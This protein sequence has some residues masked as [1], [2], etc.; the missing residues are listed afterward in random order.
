MNR[1]HSLAVII[2]ILVTTVAAFV[3]V[4]REKLGNVARNLSP[5][6]QNESAK[7]AEEF[8]AK[9]PKAECNFPDDGVAYQSAM[10]Q[11]NPTLCSCVKN[12]QQRSSCEK[13]AVELVKYQAIV[14]QLDAER[15]KELGSEQYLKM[16]QQAIA[17]RLEFMA[18]D[19]LLL[20]EG[21]MQSGNYA[22]A[23]DVLSAAVQKDDKN[24]EAILNLALAYAARGLAEHSENVYV[25]KALELV[26]KALAINENSPEAYRVRGY[27]F[28]VKPDFDEAVLNYT[29]SIQ[30][31]QNYVLSYVGRGHAYNMLGQIG[32]ALG[33]FNKAKELDTKK[34][35]PQVYSQLCRLES[36]GPLLEEAIADCSVSVEVAN[37]GD[38]AEAH[39]MLAGLFLRAN[40][41]EQARM[42]VEL[43]LSI[44]PNN[45][46]ILLTSSSVLE[47]QGDLDEAKK[48]AERAVTLDQT[49][50]AGYL[51][52]GNLALKQ[53]NYDSAILNGQKALSLVD[54]DVAVLAP[55]KASVKQECYT[56]LADAYAKK[57]DAANESKYREMG[58]TQAE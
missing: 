22:K 34:E 44:S 39:G 41:L 2:L 27:I 20:A 26:D 37:G 16:C 49:R 38:K 58:S 42:N 43:A 9:L 23:S 29:R 25:D 53:G 28:E 51:Q 6:K 33:D 1:K 21:Y 56:L 40:Q 7:T 35:Y 47:E 12:E 52:L 15:C 14:R 4:Y 5:L 31:D 17:S 45:P 46:N 36:Q 19:P 30:L 54:S 24:V 13:S 3:F 50:A 55:E 10:E 32:S 18:N 11:V 57:G 48:D 8:F